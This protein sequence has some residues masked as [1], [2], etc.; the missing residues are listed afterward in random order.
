MQMSDIQ[1]GDNITIILGKYKGYSGI[2][3]DKGVTDRVKIDAVNVS[4]LANP[5]CISWVSINNIKLLK[6]SN[7][8][9]KSRS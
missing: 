2:I 3:L 8:E 1:R 4:K 7:H 6:L 9:H 5:R